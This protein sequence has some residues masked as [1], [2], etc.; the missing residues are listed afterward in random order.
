MPPGFSQKKSSEITLE[1]IWEIFS[2]PAQGFLHRF[3]QA[4]LTEIFAGITPAVI[5]SP[6]TPEIT[7]R[8]LPG[9]EQIFLRFHSSF[10]FLG[11]LYE[12]APIIHFGILSSIP[13]V[14]V[15]WI[16]AE[17]H[18]QIPSD[19]PSRNLCVIPPQTRNFWRKSPCDSS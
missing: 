14:I 19:I 12:V 1:I 18:P 2:S 17:I 13:P 11:I 16:P 10:L 7:Q 3:L 6:I 9:F 15:A 8:I 5:F 4:F